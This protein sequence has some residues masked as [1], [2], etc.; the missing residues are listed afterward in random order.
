LTGDGREG[1]TG[2]RSNRIQCGYTTESAN[3][4]Q[5]QTFFS[6]LASIRFGARTPFSLVVRS[7][8]QAERGEPCR[9][10]KQGKSARASCSLPSPG[11]VDVLCLC[12][13]CQPFSVFRDSRGCTA[14]EHKSFGTTFEEHG[15]AISHVRMILPAV[16]LMEQV[17]GFEKVSKKKNAGTFKRRFM[18]A[19]MSIPS[20][21]DDSP[22]FAAA[23][24][25]Y[26]NSLTFVNASRPRRPE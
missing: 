14:E 17:L 5:Y 16:F 8:C 20:A 11:E 13:P 1:Q 19:I 7:A 24:C 3:H 9:Q 6:H 10:H 25:I 21:S 23:V 12:T 26:A 15:S 18:D 4:V 2:T 22:H